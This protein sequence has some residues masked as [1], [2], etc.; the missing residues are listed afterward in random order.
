MTHSTAAALGSDGEP[1]AERLGGGFVCARGE[2]HAGAA[3]APGGEAAARDSRL[4]LEFGPAGSGEA[5]GV[6][7]SVCTPL[8]KEARVAA[9]AKSQ[10]NWSGS[11]A[12]APA[13]ATGN[14]SELEAAGEEAAG[15]EAE[16]GD[17]EGDGRSAAAAAP[18]SPTES[19]RRDEML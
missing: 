1:V 2:L 12:R 5:V 9:A 3:L 13:P 17:G 10:R 7:V 19:I 14:V 8:T 6:L 4:G 15:E 11:G 18:D 16:E